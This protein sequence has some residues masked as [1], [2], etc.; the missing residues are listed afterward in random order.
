MTDWE[1]QR[2][3]IKRRVAAAE[4]RL[5]ELHLRRVELASRQSTTRN[6]ER[7]HQRVR[8]A[9]EH[10]AAARFAAV[11]Q[12]ERSAD[13]H[14]VAARAHDAAARRAGNDFLAIA[15]AH[16]AEAHRSAARHDRKLVAEYR[17]KRGQLDSLM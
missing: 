17:E 8:D 5:E 14:D 6:L 15:H 4:Q 2:L 16:I 10:A 3:R 7:A 1:T 11:N 9:V 13:A 12:L